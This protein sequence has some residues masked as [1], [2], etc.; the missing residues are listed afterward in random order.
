MGKLKLTGEAEPTPHSHPET[1]IED[2]SLLARVDDDES[3]SGQ[4]DFSG[5]RL[6]LT[7]DVDAAKPTTGNQEG[8]IFWATDTDKLYVWDGAAWKEIGGGGAAAVGGLQNLVE[9]GGFEESNISGYDPSGWAKELTPTSV[10]TSTDVAADA[11]GTYSINISANAADEGIKQTLRY[12]KANT[13]YY[14]F[15]RAKAGSGAT[16]RLLT[17]GAATN[18]DVSTTST[19]WTS[20]S[21]TFTTDA[22]G[23]NVVLKLLVAAG[24]SALFDDV[25]VAEGTAAKPFAPHL[26]DFLLYAVH[27]QNP[28]QGNVQHARL[29]LETGVKAIVVSNSPS[30]SDIVIFSRAFSRPLV[31]LACAQD[32]LWNVAAAQPSTSAMSIAIRHIDGSTFSGTI[33]V[34]W[35]V[36]GVGG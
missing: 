6:R 31:G 18:L 10:L 28:T 33:N 21:G 29:R 17:T 19:T 5:G 15:A 8:H 25:L 14:V 23:S 26:R 35:L 7:Q 36:I 11:A 13:E 27:H 32:P 3:I 12:L 24:S 2:G 20:L 30:A 4:W 22:S 9:N 34:N 1:D 16:A